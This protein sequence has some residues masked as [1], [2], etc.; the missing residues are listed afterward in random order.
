MVYME[1]P[2]ELQDLAQGMKLNSGEYNYNVV[3]NAFTSCF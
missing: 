3:E 1:T 2:P